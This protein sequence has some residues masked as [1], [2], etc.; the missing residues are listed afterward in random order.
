MPRPIC[1]LV[2]ISDPHF[3]DRFVIDGEKR[4]RDVFGRI[5]GL[6]HITKLYPHGYQTAG[7]VAFAVRRILNDRKEKGI[8]FVVVHTGDLTASGSDAE[9]SVGITFL[10]HGHYLTKTTV[11]GLR[12]SDV[13]NQVPFEVPGNHDLWHRG[14]PKD[15]TAFSS[16]Y[17]GS[18]PRS[19]R[20]N[21]EA[22]E[23][24]VYGLD[25]NR[26]SLWPH[27]LANGEIPAAD[28]A[29]LCE[30]LDR[31]RNSRA[32]KVVCLHHPLFLP[33]G[34]PRICG[35]EILRLRS[36]EKIAKLLS[37]AG[38]HIVLAGHVH[39]QQYSKKFSLL[40]FVAGSM[41][42]IN[43]R[44]SFWMLDLYPKCVEYAYFHIPNGEY[45]FDRDE[46]LSG[47]AP[48]LQP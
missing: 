32:I 19:T 10:R 27:R 34:A 17:G 28:L 23:V 2:H 20:I 40:Q 33:I 1:T 8:P 30:E 5:P 46:S 18:Y 16:H 4:W 35:V 21:S 41:C 37:D 43:S 12:L 25:S 38:A 22:G 9:F 26:S 45:H 13:Y 39:N 42:Q 14:S 36:R 44:P 11:C 47:Y 7:A 29:S 48:Y 3:G 24:I 6:R 31:E 15:H